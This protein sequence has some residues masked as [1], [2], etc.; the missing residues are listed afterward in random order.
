[1]NLRFPLFCMLVL[2]DALTPT[3]AQST[4]TPAGH[5][6]GAISLPG[7]E[8]AIRVDLEKAP[9]AWSGSIDILVQGLRGF[10]LADVKVEGEAVSFAMPGI[11]GD[12]KFAGKLAADG[13]TI[14]GEFTQAGRT[15]PFKIERKPKPA[16]VAGETPARGVPGKGLIGHWQ[17]SLKPTPVIEL[18]LVLEITNTPAGEPGGVMVSADQGG[19]RIPITALTE[20]EGRVSFETKSVGGTFDG[21][22]SADG[23]EI[24]GSWRQGGN[25]LPLTFKRLAGAPKL[26]RPQEPM[27]PYPYDEEEVVFDNDVDGVRL[28]G[29]FTKPRGAGPHPAVVLL[30]GSGPQDR[31]E[32][33]MGHRPFLVLADHLTRHG[34]AVLRN[35]DRGIGKSTGDFGQATHDDFVGDALAAVGWLKARKEIDAKRIGLVGHSEGGI[36]APLAAVKQPGDIAF[37]VLLAGVG[38]PM[39]QLLVRQSQDI[40]RVMGADADA[41]GKSVASQ[42]EVFRLLNEGLDRPVLEQRLREI[43]R[44]Q[45]AELTDEQRTAL[46][47]TDAM[48]ET[49]IQTVLTPWF[50]KLLPYDPRPTLRQVKC[51]VLA[52][53]GAKDLQVA[54][55]ENLEAIET[56]LRE[57][58]N[59][60]VKTVE[61]PGLNHLFQHCTMG[62]VAEYG[63]IEETINP[64]A[65][66]LVSGWIRD[67]AGRK[68]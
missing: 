50:L 67:Q 15:H 18:R 29:T 45:L 4:A 11:P 30:T 16:G 57:G 2:F 27:K 65:L 8:L 5:W 14:G 17:G 7:T 53:N 9:G 25:V 55:K 31:D 22:L 63:Q 52:I 10:R 54:A 59:N 61:L 47:F 24:D 68:R 62:A 33:I 60:R 1:M 21:S 51:P 36:V 32:A 34:V 46:G 58:G 43:S 42:R 3:G 44:Q 20:K 39:D 23:S 35:D 26:S 66:E 56:A 64:A 19:A 28:A 49:Q 13:R 38:V 41:L 48:L 40:A 37:L 12:P 6:E